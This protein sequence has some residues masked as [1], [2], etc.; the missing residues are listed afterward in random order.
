VSRDIFSENLS[1]I[2]CILA[3]FFEGKR[4]TC[5]GIIKMSRQ[6]PRQ[7]HR[8]TQGE[9]GGSKIDQKKCHVL[10]EWPLAESSKDV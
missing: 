2:F 3:C 8:K 6:S 1:D 4:A 7:F 9:A 10:F 5:F